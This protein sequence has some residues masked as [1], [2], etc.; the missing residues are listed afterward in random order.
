MQSAHGAG[1]SCGDFLKQPAGGGVLRS[2]LS[3]VQSFQR[4][5]ACS[6]KF[7]GH[8][9]PLRFPRTVVGNNSHTQPCIMEVTLVIPKSL[10]LIWRCECELEKCL[11]MSPLFLPRGPSLSPPLS[12][13]S[14]PLY[15]VRGQTQDFV[16][17]CL[18]LSMQQINKMCS[19]LKIASEPSAVHTKHFV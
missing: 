4:L 18:P 16:S 10:Y 8:P 15:P 3:C 9:L 14:F 17:L 2:A 5:L 12:L 13:V 6:S 19:W 7:A 1:V 11:L